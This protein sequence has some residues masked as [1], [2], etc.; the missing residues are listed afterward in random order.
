V[1]GPLRSGAST[2]ELDGAA[3][4]LEARRRPATEREQ[5]RQVRTE[6]SAAERN[7]ASDPRPPG[8]LRAVARVP[9]LPRLFG[10]RSGVAVPA[11]VPL[12][13]DGAGTSGTTAS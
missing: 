1:V 8:V 6:R 10:R 9:G 13:R 2:A 3:A 11:P 5:Q 4:R 7:R 12:I